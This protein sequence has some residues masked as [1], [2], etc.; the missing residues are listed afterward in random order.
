MVSLKS[1]GRL[2]SRIRIKRE[3]L[4]LKVRQAAAQMDMDASILSKIETGKRLPTDDQLSAIAECL[5]LHLGG[6]QEC[7]V[8]ERILHEYQNNPAFP[9]A[10]KMVAELAPEYGKTTT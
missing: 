9:N 5:T 10:L 1:S 8:A 4:R 7:L 2:G 6:L 3:Q